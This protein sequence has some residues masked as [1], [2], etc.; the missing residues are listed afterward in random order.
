MDI[1]KARFADRLQFTTDIDPSC[2]DAK[3]PALTLQ[4]IVEN[5]V[6]HAVEPQEDGGS[7]RF[8]VYEEEDG[9]AVEI[10][11]DGAGMLREKIRQIVEEEALPEGHSTGIGFSNVVKRLRLF[12]GVE[13]VIEIESEEGK[14]TTITLRIKRE[15]AENHDQVAHR[16]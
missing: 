6:I 15:G 12:Y 8:R 10:S 4:P 13:D 9:I 11:D 5:A 14:G 7:I 3:I 2:L 16:G 1:Q